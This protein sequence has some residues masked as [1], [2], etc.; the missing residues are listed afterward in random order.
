MPVEG[1]VVSANQALYVVIAA[2]T[3]PW[4]LIVVAAVVFVRPNLTA[5]AEGLSAR[6][7]SI[8]HLPAVEVGFAT[9]RSFVLVAAVDFVDWQNYLVN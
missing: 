8:V 6:L 4:N 2:E 9:K 1:T 3:E 7:N 5:V